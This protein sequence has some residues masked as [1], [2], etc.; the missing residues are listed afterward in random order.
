MLTFKTN[1]QKRTEI[2]CMQRLQKDERTQQHILEECYT[3]IRTT[4][5]K[6]QNG[7]FEGRNKNI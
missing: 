5:E 2:P 3:Y 4:H 7:P 1:Y 6:S